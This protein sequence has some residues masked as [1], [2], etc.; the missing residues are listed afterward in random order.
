MEDKTNAVFLKRLIAYL[1]DAFLISLAASLLSM[2][3]VDTSNDE[4]MQ[5]EV[6]EITESLMQDEI[7]V[8]TYLTEYSSLYYQINRNQGIVV[9]VSLFLEVAY[10]IALQFYMGGQTIGKKIARIKVVANDGELT[11]NTLIARSFLI[12]SI[13]MHIISL[14]CITFLKV[15]MNY[16]YVVGTFEAV[17]L[18]FLFVTVLMVMYSK[19]K[20]GVHDRITNTSVINC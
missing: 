20:R 1:I 4:K 9:L 3:F 7:S 18:G 12:D 6:M 14:I 13:L 5:K 10:Y 15:P 11:M 19:D 16:F 2:P 17:Q 8:N